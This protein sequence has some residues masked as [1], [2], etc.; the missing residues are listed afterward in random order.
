MEDTMIHV[1][2]G[3]LKKGGKEKKKKQSPQLVPL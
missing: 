3:H 2:S 1:E